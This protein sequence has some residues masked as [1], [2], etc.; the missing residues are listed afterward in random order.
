MNPKKAQAAAKNTAGQAAAGGAAGQAAV[1]L[2]IFG[3]IL[4]FILGAIVRSAVSSGYAQNQNFTAMRMAMLASWQGTEAN[5]G[6]GAV[7][8]VARN[9]ASVIFVED[10]LSPD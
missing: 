3:A 6:A 9:N 5:P 7:Q 10:R 4:I 1:E 2:A 8:N